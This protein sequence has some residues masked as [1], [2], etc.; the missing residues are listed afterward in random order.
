MNTNDPR[1]WI[2][3]ALIVVGLVALAWVLE[4]ER[5]RRQSIRLQQRFG[6]EYRRIVAE[7]GDRDK[8]ETELVAREKRVEHLKIIPL[9]AE[10]AA[11]FSQ[12]WGVL[13]SRFVDQPKSVV[14]E[15][16]QL[17]RD[18]MVKRGYP[19]GDFER[20][21]ADIS[22]HHPTVVD[23]YRSAQAIAGRAQRGNASTEDLRKAVVFYRALFDELLE[24]RVARRDSK[25][26]KDKD[27]AV[28]P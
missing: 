23:T 15:A 2:M 24:V 27:V 17:V 22:V 9:T 25:R 1:F 5:K 14:V 4:R 21:A 10:D 19:M 11:R 6:P 18:L 28:H 8:A 7:R 3:A 16:D 13:Q 12:A 20:R 26:E